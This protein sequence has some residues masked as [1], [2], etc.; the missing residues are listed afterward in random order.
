MPK[1]DRCDLYKGC[2]TPCMPLTGLPLN[3]LMFVGEAPGSVEDGQ[4]VAFVGDAGILLNRVLKRIGI[5]RKECALANACRCRPPGNREPSPK[6][7][8]ACKYYLSTDIATT[9]P[10]VIVPMGNSALLSVLSMKGITKVRGGVFQT[11]EFPGVYIVPTLHPSYALRRW[12]GE[13]IIERDLRLAYRICQEGSY[14]PLAT[15]YRTCGSVEDIVALLARLSVSATMV[16]FDTETTGFDFWT[17]KIICLSFSAKEGTGWVVPLY[18]Q[19]MRQLWTPAEFDTIVGALRKFFSSSAPKCAQNGVFDILMLR[20]NFNMEVENWVFDTMLMHHAVDENQA[21][22]LE[23]LSSWYTDL[24]PYKKE[25]HDHLPK[26]TSSYS[27]VPEDILWK[28]A[29]G[30]ADS[31]LRVANC[32]AAEAAEDDVTEVHDR[33]MI[34]LARVLA[35]AE[36][37]GVR[38]DMQALEALDKEYRDKQ[39]EI[40]AEIYELAY[41]E[42]NVDSHKQRA[43]VLFDKLGLPVSKLTAG[44]NRST[45]SEVMSQLAKKHPIA[46]RLLDLSGIG[47]DLKNYLKGKDGKSGILKYLHADGR[48]HPRWMQHR[49]VT[50]R[51]SSSDPNVQAIKKRGLGGEKTGKFRQLF[52]ATEGWYWI[53]FDYK[54]M[55]AYIAGYVAPDERLIAMHRNKEDVHRL[56]GSQMFHVAPPDVNEVQRDRAKG[57]VFGLNYGRQEY[58]LAADFGISIDEAR[59][60]IKSY[61]GL[62]VGVA[63]H[64]KNVAHLVNTK[65]EIQTPFKR[66]RHFYGVAT[67]K[68]ALARG[69]YAAVAKKDA[70]R[71][72]REMHRM[73]INVTIQSPANDILGLACIRIHKRFKDLGMQA[74]LLISQH[75]AWHGECPED[76]LEDAVAIVKE[77]LER[78]VPEMHDASFDVDVSIG[79]YWGDDSVT[80][81]GV[82]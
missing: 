36:W 70:E 12:E 16:A 61:F 69:F 10:K 57:V 23:F 65:F 82:R 64:F 17:D 34:P 60:Y 30:D 76:E 54:S 50:G 42:F 20:G 6:E 7:V 68:Q 33:I 47:H 21:H 49:A 39:R 19:Y 15:D 31:T 56:V 9:Q 3:G 22:S 2:Q 45:D 32:L 79:R 52:A 48:V 13:K 5:D 63:E 62:F 74:R 25:F 78:P 43:R 71:A 35:D 4:G 80:L 44:G 67:L 77:E 58:S 41:G 28:Y 46:R 55:E 40:L 18:G 37:D 59:E 14:T 27:E 72:L 38:V 51:L 8:A 73:A 26:S 66:K 53:S 29:A 24:D 1:C 75:D 81:K 11:A